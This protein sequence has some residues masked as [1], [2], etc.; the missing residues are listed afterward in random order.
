MQGWALLESHVK[1][2]ISLYLMIENHLDV[3]TFSFHVWVIDFLTV[4]GTT[5]K[6]YIIWI[7]HFPNNMQL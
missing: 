5:N 7:L 1:V 2:I 3:N 4:H 6:V